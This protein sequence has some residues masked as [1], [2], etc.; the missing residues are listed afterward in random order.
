MAMVSSFYDIRIASLSL[1][2]LMTW[3][4]TMEEK[5]PVSVTSHQSSQKR[6]ALLLLRR[7]CTV[8]KV[9]DKDNLLTSKI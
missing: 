1:G 8:T 5:E 4:A 7:D 9:K 2:S 3:W 6:E